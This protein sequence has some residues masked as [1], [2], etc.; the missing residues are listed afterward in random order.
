MQRDAGKLL[1][2]TCMPVTLAEVTA[3][4]G[5]AVLPR[6]ILHVKCVRGF[7]CPLCPGQA[8][9]PGRELCVR[10]HLSSC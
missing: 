9:G 10:C 5:R 4:R 7:V 3:S 8:V 6:R 1:G 2:V